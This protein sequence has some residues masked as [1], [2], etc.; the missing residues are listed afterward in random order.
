MCEEERGREGC[1]VTAERSA[2]RLGLYSYLTTRSG[3]RFY[4]R[5][6]LGGGD[7][8]VATFVDRFTLTGVTGVVVLI[9]LFART[10]VF[11]PV[12]EC[13]RKRKW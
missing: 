13:A 4:W 2:L 11:G 7:H 12:I 10:A 8:D 5:D 6:V 1:I 3:A 9:T